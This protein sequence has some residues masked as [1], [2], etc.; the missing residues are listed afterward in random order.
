MEE[1]NTGTVVEGGGFVVV[2]T[3]TL[4]A[5]PFLAFVFLSLPLTEF[6]DLI[7]AL[8]LGEF[9]SFFI[10]L[11]SGSIGFSFAISGEMGEPTASDESEES[12]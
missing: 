8:D 10:F 12:G 7:E 4:G 3:I 5:E 6:L 2:G 1:G 9:L 11:G